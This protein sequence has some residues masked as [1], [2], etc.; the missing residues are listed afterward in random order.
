MAADSSDEELLESVTTAQRAGDQA[1]GDESLSDNDAM[2]DDAA[3][4]DDSTPA[5]MFAMAM[6][7]IDNL[8]IPRVDGHMRTYTVYNLL[9]Y[10]MHNI[11]KQHN[12]VLH[13]MH[14]A[15]LL[16]KYGLGYL[17]P[18]S[19]QAQQ[20]FAYKNIPLISKFTAGPKGMHI[21]GVHCSPRNTTN[22]N[23][24]A[25]TNTTRQYK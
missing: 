9:I 22:T 2:N 12:K 10:Q 3:V 25:G 6:H 5:V 17:A 24:N 13:V 15:I 23:I 8:C 4:T 16:I 19:R 18:G 1:N 14:I 21:T 20:S 11:S 7:R